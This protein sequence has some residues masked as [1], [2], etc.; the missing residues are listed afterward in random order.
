[1][2]G[3]V[4]VSEKSSS[5]LKLAEEAVRKIVR[6]YILSLDLNFN[7]VGRFGPEQAEVMPSAMNIEKLKVIFAKYHPIDFMLWKFDGNEIPCNLFFDPAWSMDPEIYTGLLYKIMEVDK[8]FIQTAGLFFP[9]LPQKYLSFFERFLPFAYMDDVM[10]TCTI[11]GAMVCK[12]AANIALVNLVK[13][14]IE[15][16]ELI[17]QWAS[18]IDS[19]KITADQSPNKT[20]NLYQFP[21]GDTP[22]E[23]MQIILLQDKD[24]KIKIKF[25]LQDK[26]PLELT[27]GEAGLAHKRNNDRPINAFAT[28]MQLAKAKGGPIPLNKQQVSDLNMKLKKILVI[29]YCPIKSIG[30]GKY[31]ASFKCHISK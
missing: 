5:E 14:R 12:P 19:E 28:L 16:V 30:N 13:S 7:E 9:S 21:I 18:I 8:A 22:I 27:P 24:D 1:V 17:L 25:H 2:G 20:I 23:N 31:K 29:N 11:K 4:M 3:A 15:S 10:N 6:K 26:E